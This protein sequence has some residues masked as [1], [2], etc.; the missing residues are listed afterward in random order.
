M[1]KISILEL[2]DEDFIERKNMWS[3]VFGT[4]HKSKQE[5][6]KKFAEEL[7]TWEENNSKIIRELTSPLRI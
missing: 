5:N 1:K 6:N 4:Q 2:Y 3:Y 7:Y